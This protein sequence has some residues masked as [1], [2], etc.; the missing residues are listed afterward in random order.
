M[1]PIRLYGKAGWPAEK[2]SE[3]LPSRERMVAMATKKKRSSTRTQSLSKSRP[4][5]YGEMYKNETTVQQPT[6][7]AAPKANTVTVAESRDWRVEYSHVVRDLR[8]LLIVSAVLF[9][10]IIVTGFFM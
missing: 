7:T 2:I 1:L 9:A 6:V 5:S 4:R 8:T 3:A 10:V